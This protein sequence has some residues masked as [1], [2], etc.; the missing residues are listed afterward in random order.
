MA[1]VIHSVTFHPSGRGKAQCAPDP[2][3]PHGQEICLEANVSP[4]CVVALPYPAPEC[5]VFFI[6]CTACKMT[7]V[8][9][10]AGRPDDPISVEIPCDFSQEGETQ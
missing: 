10:A 7:V 5:G 6:K 2:A 9:T 3:Y 8:V 1:K 4:K